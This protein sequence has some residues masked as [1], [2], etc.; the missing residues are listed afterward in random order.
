MNIK[1]I[2]FGSI[3]EVIGR[4][5]IEMDTVSDVDSLKLKLVKDFPKLSECKFVIAVNKTIV[6]GNY[7]FNNADTVA[8]LPPFAGG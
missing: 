6:S 7:K 2:F 1:V 5:Q 4:N 3:A 8:L